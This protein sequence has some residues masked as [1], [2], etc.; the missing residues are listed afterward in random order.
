MKG[1]KLYGC[2]TC[3]F[4]GALWDKKTLYC[5]RH[6]MILDAMRDNC[7]TWD[8]RCPAGVKERIERALEEIWEKVSGRK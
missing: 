4:F 3:I 1:K 6:H 5:G 8:E 2:D 7:F